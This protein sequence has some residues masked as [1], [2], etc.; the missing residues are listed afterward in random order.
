M[1]AL[2]K[3][4]LQSSP[5]R[6]SSSFKRDL[7]MNVQYENN[8]HSD[9]DSDD[10]EKKS[11]Y[12]DPMVCGLPGPDSSVFGGKSKRRLR[13]ENEQTY[14]AEKKTKASASRRRIEAMALPN[15]MQHAET[16]TSPGAASY[17]ISWSL[18]FP[19]A[20]FRESLPSRERKNMA[21]RGISFST[22]NV[23]SEVEKQISRASKIPGPGEYSLP[24]LGQILGAGR[25]PGGQS[26]SE[27]DWIQYRARQLP[28][29][30]QYDIRGTDPPIPGGRFS[31]SKMKTEV[32]VTPGPGDY[33]LPGIANGDGPAAR[34]GRSKR[35]SALDMQLLEAAR[36]PGPGAYEVEASFKARDRP[37]GMV[38]PSTSH[39]DALRELLAEA[40]ARP[41]PG[42]FW[43]NK[44]AD[45]ALKGGR[46]NT[47]VVPTYADVIIS[48]SREVPGPGL[49]SLRTGLRSRGTKF[50]GSEALSQLDLELRRAKDLPGPSDYATDDRVESR[51]SG[52]K[53]NLAVP[54]SPLDK[55][56]NLAKKQP[57]PG[58]YNV[59]G[60]TRFGDGIA[61]FG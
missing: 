1:S 26:K 57:G 61:T 20:E 36:K 13:E 58:Q 25:F 33:M 12:T 40:A 23:P 11:F 15:P 39:D 47:A 28:G 16:H 30:G 38:F 18:A 56:I 22:A 37:R 10:E 55:V 31:T 34:I 35:I 5:Y 3:F 7:V 21:K 27:L 60:R 24:R 59:T 17:D 54:P 2:E 19:S 9:S 46:F 45:E 49:Y 6:R 53:F 44:G 29:P 52:G 50:G 42:E 43:E 51:L 14:L 41:G 8:G 48:Q 32:K 4:E